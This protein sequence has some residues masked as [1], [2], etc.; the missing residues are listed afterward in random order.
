MRAMRPNVTCAV[1]ANTTVGKPLKLRAYGAIQI[2]LL[3]LLFF[4]FFVVFI[5]Q[6]VKIPGVKN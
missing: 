6:V 2:R 5:P 1:T 4:L 3:L